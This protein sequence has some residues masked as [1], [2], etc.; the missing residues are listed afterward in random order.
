MERKGREKEKKKR[1]EKRLTRAPIPWLAPV[2]MT[3][4][5]AKDSAGVDGSIDGYTSL[6]TCLVNCMLVTKKS[7]GRESIA[8]KWCWC[9]YMGGFYFVERSG[10]F[11]KVLLK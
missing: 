7:V 2:M 5:L 9:F 10:R 8:K 11:W 4:L 3:T 6:E 1:K